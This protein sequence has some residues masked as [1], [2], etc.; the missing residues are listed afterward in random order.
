MATGITTIVG[1]ILQC[2]P[3]ARNWDTTTP[4]RCLDKLDFARY[5]AIPNVITG[6]AMLVLPLPMVWRLNVTFQQ[7]IALTATF[8]HGIIG[9]VASIA[10]LA[11]LFGSGETRDTNRLAISWTI[12][13]MVEPANYVIAACLPT[14]RPIFM[15]I[16]PQNFFL[17]SHKRKS[18][19][20]SSVKI[21]WPKGRATP[22]IT[23]ASADIHG[24]SHLTGPWDASRVTREDL[25]A[26]TT[27]WEWKAQARTVL[28]ETREVTPSP[29]LVNGSTNRL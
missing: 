6:F 2:T 26:N 3:I 21:S 19:S 24:P 17:L 15:R 4:G 22:K 8:L 14:L 9:F 27:D 12:W 20:Y 1:S 23:L 25:E 18:K 29:T 16:L 5:T 11:I 28:Q 7:K 13:T 10:R